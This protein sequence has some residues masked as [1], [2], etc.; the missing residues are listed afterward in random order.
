MEVAYELAARLDEAGNEVFLQLCNWHAAE[1]IKKRLTREGYPMDPKAELVD[2]VWKWIKS[3]TML[4]L[5]TNRRKILDSL[6]VKEQAYFISYY[7]PKEHQFIRAYIKLLPNL[8]CYSSQRSEGL[9]PLIKGVVNRHTP[10]GQ[11]VEK[12]TENI[13][14]LVRSHEHAINQQK[15]NLP[16]LID[17]SR[18]AFRK[19]SLFI[20]HE[21][22]ELILREWNLAK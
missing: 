3:E 15:K 2:H 13:D 1:A 21:A 22:V 6:R 11:S 12:I 16:R 19:I 4:E 8:G 7:Q 14:E 10:I 20:T 18:E 17:M 9:H 5:A